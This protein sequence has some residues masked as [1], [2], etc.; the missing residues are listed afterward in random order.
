MKVKNVILAICLVGFALSIL[1]KPRHHRDQLQQVTTIS[2]TIAEWAYND[3]FEYDRLYL[4][5]GNTTIFVK[6]PP[7]LAKQARA[8]GNNLTVNGVFHVNREGV[9]ELK[10][11]S[12]SGNGK[13][14][15]DQKPIRQIT[16]FQESFVSGEGKVS[17]VQ[18]N[19][20]GA[21]HGYILDNGIVLR[22]SPRSA[23]QLS[24]MIHVG[25]VIGYSGIKKALK[26]GHVRAYNYKQVHS[27]TL[28]VNGTQYAVR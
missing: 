24:Q 5:T 8:L 27:Q 19:K 9:Q 25:S 26:K 14:V 11:V 7:H 21:V 2:G 12:M 17:Q 16:Y 6:F 15:Y 22:I 18:L 3:D 13:T 23:W 20:S 1:A 28:S 4:N 10:M